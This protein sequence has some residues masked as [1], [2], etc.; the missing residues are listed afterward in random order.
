MLVIIILSKIALKL[1]TFCQTTKNIAKNV[2]KSN[3]LAQKATT[4]RVDQRVLHKKAGNVLSRPQ[5]G[6]RARKMTNISTFGQN[7]LSYRSLSCTF[8]TINLFSH[9][10]RE[11]DYHRD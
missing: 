5:G 4:F 9:Y 6:A 10:G 7:Y 8:A 1:R 3:K 2:P 11:K